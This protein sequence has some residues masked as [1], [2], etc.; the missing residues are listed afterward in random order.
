MFPRTTPE[1]LRKEIITKINYLKLQADSI[2]PHLPPEGVP[3]SELVDLRFLLM[4]IN[5]K[6]NK[7]KE[8]L[9]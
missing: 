2:G 6:L 1:E 3:L 7:L 8:K 4:D 9:P 5:R